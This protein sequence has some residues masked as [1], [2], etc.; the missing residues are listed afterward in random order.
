MFQAPTRAQDCDPT[1]NAQIQCT[2]CP[3]TLLTPEAHGPVCAG[4]A[5]VD[6]ALRLE[7]PTSVGC[8]AGNRW[9][10]GQ[11]HAVHARCRT[12]PWGLLQQA[13][14]HTQP[15]VRSQYSGVVSSPELSESY[16]DVARELYLRLH[17]QAAAAAPR[18]AGVRRQVT[19]RQEAPGATPTYPSDPLLL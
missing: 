12:A 15:G 9:V 14:A 10:R 17:S 5:A 19:G 1:S 4:D 3:P 13:P 16:S 2:G 8:I 11:N 6:T 7:C 18:R